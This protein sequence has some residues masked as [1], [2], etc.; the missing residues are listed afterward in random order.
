MGF[1]DKVFKGMGSAAAS[2]AHQDAYHRVKVG[3]CVVLLEVAAADDMISDAEISKIVEMLK[4]RFELEDEDA[5]ELIA[6]SKEER[7]KAVDLWK[8]TNM[9]NETLTIEQKYQVAEMA[10]N[11]IFSDKTLDKFEDHLAHKLISLL[12]LEHAKFMD[13]KIRVK[14]THSVM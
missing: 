9:L 2:P 11:V 6:I 13:I 14:K 4:R 8:F 12:N 5:K 1:F 3:T 10:W 7:S